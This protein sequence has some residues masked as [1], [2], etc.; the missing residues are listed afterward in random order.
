MCELIGG[1]VDGSILIEDQP[2]DF[3]FITPG[4]LQIGVTFADDPHYESRGDFA[5]IYCLDSAGGCGYFAGYDFP[6]TGAK[7]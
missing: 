5:A 1:P 2:H 6:E 7:K 3:V 4:V